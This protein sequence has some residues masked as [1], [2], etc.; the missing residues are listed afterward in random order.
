MLHIRKIAILVSTSGPKSFTMVKDATCKY[1][2][3]TAKV[4]FRKNATAEVS[5]WFGG[6]VRSVERLFDTYVPNVRIVAAV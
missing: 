1:A 6:I 2:T 4:L 5:R 3:T